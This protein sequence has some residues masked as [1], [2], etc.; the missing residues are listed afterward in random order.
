[1]YICVIIFRLLT[2]T[3]KYFNDSKDGDV[4][5]NA[6]P[7][8]FDGP[9]K[10]QI[11][12]VIVYGFLCVAILTGSVAIYIYKRENY[13]NGNNGYFVI[14]FTIIRLL[15]EKNLEIRLKCCKHVSIWKEKGKGTLL[16]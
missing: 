7:E 2:T 3:D 10:L 1:M 6:K 9:I 14:L 5:K 8:T 4:L 16:K 15:T 13:K 12:I 11:V